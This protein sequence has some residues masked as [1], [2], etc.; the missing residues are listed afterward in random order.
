[1]CFVAGISHVLKLSE[2]IQLQLILLYFAIQQRSVQSG[3][4]QLLQAIPNYIIINYSTDMY[5]Y[6]YTNVLISKFRLYS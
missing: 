4:N 2:R 6:I 1:M 5:Y 3:S